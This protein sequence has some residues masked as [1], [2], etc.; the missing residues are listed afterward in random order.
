VCS[1]FHT[2]RQSMHVRDARAVP[3]AADSR[4]RSIRSVASRGRASYPKMATS[5][6]R[7][8]MT[9]TRLTLALS[10]GS[11][12]AGGVTGNLNEESQSHGLVAMRAMLAPAASAA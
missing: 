5:I 7:S 1:S 12:A 4:R 3:P 11:G 6:G 10:R 9:R 2:P 8:A